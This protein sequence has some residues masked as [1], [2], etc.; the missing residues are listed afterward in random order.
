MTSKRNKAMK[1]VLLLNFAT[2]WI[3]MFKGIDLTQLGVGLAAINTPVF[4]YMWGETNRP[5]KD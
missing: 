2:F 1:I 4:A 3:G 5:S